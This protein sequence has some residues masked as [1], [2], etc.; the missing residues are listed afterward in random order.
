M[1]LN[2][3]YIF[4]IFSSFTF[5]QG[6]KQA[7][8]T[9]YFATQTINYV[10]KIRENG[11]TK[12]YL[13]DRQTNAFLERA[14]ARYTLGKI[15]VAL[16]DINK[17][18][19]RN[20]YILEAYY[21][22][23]QILSI[24]K[25]YASAINNFNVIVDNNLFI[26][27]V[28]AFRAEARFNL[29]RH[30]SILLDIDRFINASDLNH[31]YTGKLYFYKGAI[32][33]QQEN[34]FDA[35]ENLHIAIK[36]SPELWEAYMIRG[37]IHRIRG[38][39]DEAFM[40]L[41]IAVNSNACPREVY[42]FRGLAHS[43][44]GNFQASIEDLSEFLKLTPGYHQ[45]KPEAFLKRAIARYYE[46]DLDDVINDL[47]EVI[48]REPDHWLSFRLLGLVYLKKEKYSQALTN[49]NIAYVRGDHDV[50][51]Y[52]NRGLVQI[53]LSH[54]QKAENDLSV[55]LNKVSD[56]HHNYAKALTKRGISLFFMKRLD[57]ACIDWNY[58]L[59]L[60]YE[61]ANKFINRHCK[62]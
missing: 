23:G 12:E 13:Y 52:L 40:D 26:P 53:N 28:F 31:P 29:Y 4:F 21:Y 41:N 17:T 16:E 45:D 44:Q 7:R 33:F 49:F 60:Q 62:N 38:H 10:D 34:Y 18:I 22:R 47:N 54:Y 57:E 56:D 42:L 58:S 36:L 9:E 55:F 61:D 48:K 24:Q 15:D 8:V 30:E 43:A 46:G 3:F 20:P 2:Y 32:L 27:D 11:D 35:I 51:L 6:L 25:E 39:L 19:N 59:Q 14:K 50:E 1:R 37:N 5:S